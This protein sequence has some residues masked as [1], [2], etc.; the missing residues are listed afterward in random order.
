MVTE[1]GIKLSNFAAETY[2]PR[3]LD[4]TGA[5]ASLEPGMDE[6]G[7]YTRAGYEQNPP[8]PRLA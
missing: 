2:D 4:G 3:D 5:R 1:N 8:I 7:R 6:E